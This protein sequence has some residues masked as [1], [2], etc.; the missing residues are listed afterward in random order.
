MAFFFNIDN[1]VIESKGNN[2]RFMQLIYAKYYNLLPSR[3]NKYIPPKL[4]L[5][6]TSF[7]INI[8]PLFTSNEDIAYL[9][10]YVKLAAM[11]DYLLYKQYKKLSLPLS[12]FPDINMQNIAHN[13]LLTI[14][15]DEILFKH[16]T[17]GK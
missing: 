12:Y 8:E 15:E 17:L 14:T 13:R 5:N 16:E 11:R 6:G 10:Q 4:S 9:V 7:I 1:L 3:K 2:K